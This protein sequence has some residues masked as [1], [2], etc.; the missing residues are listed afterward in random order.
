MH[1]AC[2]SINQHSFKYKL[3]QVRLKV[4]FDIFRWL[5]LSREGPNDCFHLRQNQSKRE[6]S[7]TES[8]KYPHICISSRHSRILLSAKC[9]RYTHTLNISCTYQSTVKQSNYMCENQANQP[10]WFCCNHDRGKIDPKRSQAELQH[11]RWL[12]QEWYG[13]TR[14]VE[15]DQLIP[16]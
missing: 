9:C 11:L 5:H 15:L 13:S 3:L 8:F 6:K 14:E 16:V 7:R 12:D 2:A 4:L 10:T 1:W